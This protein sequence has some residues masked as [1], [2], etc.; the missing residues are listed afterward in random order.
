MWALLFPLSRCAI[1]LIVPLM[2]PVYWSA[3]SR[4]L[5]SITITLEM[6]VA[7][8]WMMILMAWMVGIGR[9]SHKILFFLMHLVKDLKRKKEKLF[10]SVFINFHLRA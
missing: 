4:E 10:F 9:S 8:N 7:L 5:V 1:R 6:L 2:E 3:Y